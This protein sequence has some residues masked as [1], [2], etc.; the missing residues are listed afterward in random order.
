[1]T[2]QKNLLQKGKPMGTNYYAVR[3]RPTTEEPI[4]IGKSSI[5]W[6]FNF[7]VQNE[8]WNKP[9]VIWNTYDQVY[10]WLHKYTVKSDLYVI[11]DEYDEIISF[12]DFV[13]LV[14]K[15]QSENNPDDFTYAKNVNG[16]RFSDGEFC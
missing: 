13:A 7:Q 1:M 11:I 12:D 6:K 2:L 15:K 10:E 8:K 5:G 9:P 14:E 4:H 3:N 16:Y